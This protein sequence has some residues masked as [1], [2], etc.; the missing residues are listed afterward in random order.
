MSL[1]AGDPAPSILSMPY[2]DTD[3]NELV[4]AHLL[5]Q[6]P[7]L[8]GIYKSSCGAS[9]AMMPIL[10]RF[11]DR[12]GVFGLQVAGVAQDSANVTRSFIRRSGGL[13]YPVLLEGDEYPVSIAFDIFATPTL[14]LIR[15]NGTIAYTTMGFLRVQLEEI[16][17]AVAD[18]L[19]V[20]YQPIIH[21]EVD[22]EIPLFVP[23]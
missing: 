2:P 12:Y 16:S 8:I 14:Y 19:G 3:G 21:E 9:K 6:G 23:G 17:R 11:V 20:G 7:L 10:N 22:E 13:D 18:V 1:Q 5:Q 4:L 15:Q